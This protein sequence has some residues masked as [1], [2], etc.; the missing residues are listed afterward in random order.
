MVESL[1]EPR[2]IHVFFL[3]DAYRR[4]DFLDTY[5]GLSRR[6]PALLSRQ[7]PQNRVL[8]M[9]QNQPSMVIRKGASKVTKHQKMSLK[10]KSLNCC[11]HFQAAIQ[12]CAM[13]DHGKH[14]HGGR[15]DVEGSGLGGTR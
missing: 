7:R 11:G 14:F 10:V 1:T 8:K 5:S 2:G 12:R 4:V 15:G 9:L 3:I 6:I 13:G